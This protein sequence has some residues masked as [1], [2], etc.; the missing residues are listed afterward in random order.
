MERYNRNHHHCNHSPMKKYVFGLLVVAAGIF[1]LLFNM[2]IIHEGFKEIV[3]SWQMLLIAIGLIN[4]SSRESRMIGWILVAVGGFFIIPEFYFLGTDFVI[5][6]W[7]VLLILVGI[8]ILVYGGK[9]RKF[10]L[11]HNDLKLDSGVIN[12]TNIFGGS[13]QRID[14]Q[15]F[16]G[17]TVTNIFGG[18]ELDL[19]QLELSDEKNILDVTCIFGGV[20]FIVPAEWKIT[21]QTSTILG[22]WSDKRPTIK[23]MESPRKELTITGVTIFGGGEITSYY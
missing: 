9:A 7:P 3:F 19:T 16:K 4:L 17:G 2:G 20:K 8:L 14:Q 5:N 10:R 15:E 11:R 6:F 12:E 18:S 22:G 21:M 1:L 13:K 23:N